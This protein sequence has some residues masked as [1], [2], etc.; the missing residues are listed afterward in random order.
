MGSLSI[1]QELTLLMGGDL[2]SSSSSSQSQ[3]ASAYFSSQSD[4]TTSKYFGGN[5]ESPSPPKQVSNRNA[6]VMEFDR[7]IFSPDKRDGSSRDFEGNDCKSRQ[8]EGH[9]PV[10]KSPRKR[11]ERMNNNTSGM[12]IL[13]Q[14]CSD[15]DSPENGDALDADQGLD[16][17]R[18]GFSRVA[19]DFDPLEEYYVDDGPVNQRMKQDNGM[20][21]QSSFMDQLSGDGAESSGCDRDVS[22]VIRSQNESLNEVVGKDHSADFE[23]SFTVLRSLERGDSR[24]QSVRKLDL[25]DVGEAPVKSGKSLKKRSKYFGSTSK[26]SPTKPPLKT[27]RL[28]LSPSPVLPSK[29]GFTPGSRDQRKSGNTM[30]NTFG[31]K[32]STSRTEEVGGKQP[33]MGAS[34]SSVTYDPSATSTPSIKRDLSQLANDL[35]GASVLSEKTSHATPNLVSEDGP[36]KPAHVEVVDLS[37]DTPVKAK[38]NIGGQ[39]LYFLSV[40]FCF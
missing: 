25:S 5:E 15:Q 8:M 26:V 22:P 9:I 1:E 7:S 10:R 4:A 12:S 30:E 14:L 32:F 36:S 13:D 23:E 3:R 40:T 31:P 18:P 33:Q 28:H 37:Q 34:F 29:Q 27:R 11:A 19:D 17:G 6:V 24:W 21:A 38:R 2:G 39:L 20:D 16:G 35:S